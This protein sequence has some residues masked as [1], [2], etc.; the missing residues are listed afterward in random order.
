MEQYLRCYVNY[1]QDDWTYWLAAAEFAANNQ[2]SESTGVSPFF[3]S[4]GQ[5]PRMFPNQEAEPPRTVNE[6]EARTRARELRE[7]HGHCAA[8][9]R[10]AQLVQQEQYDRRRLHAPD[11][12]PGDLVWLDARNIRTGRPSRKLDN[13][14]M[15]P[16][17]VA[18]KISAHAYRLALPRRLGVHDVQPVGLLELASNDPLP[19][20]RT[21]APP[22]VEGPNG[23]E[24][25]VDEILNSRRFGRHQRPQYL[26]RWLGYL[27][28]D[29][30]ESAA[31]FADS[32]A[33]ETY[34]RRYPRKPGPHNNWT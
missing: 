34:H 30:W 25:L 11:F 13:P 15:G 7:I 6:Q 16:F 3:A 26:V 27:G 32:E 28:E 9:M 5:D 19:G 33:A 8:E 20:Q 10:R 12:R 17:R 4:Y 1:A 14:R 2:A 23:P 18:E 24:Y 31:Y 29:S 22:P 21:P